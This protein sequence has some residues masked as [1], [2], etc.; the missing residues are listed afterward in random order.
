MFPNEETV[1]LVLTKEVNDL[2]PYLMIVYYFFLDTDF[3]I[4]QRLKL[5]QGKETSTDF[6]DV[7]LG[8]R[9]DIMSLPDNDRP[10]ILNLTPCRAS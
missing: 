3:Y 1:F 2:D 9:R 7:M 5:L 4:S 6:H 8:R 10:I